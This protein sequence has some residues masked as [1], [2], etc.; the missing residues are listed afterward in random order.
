MP[1]EHQITTQLFPQLG[2]QAQALRL[3]PRHHRSEEQAGINTR[4]WNVS[5]VRGNS[6]LTLTPLLRVDGWEL[7]VWTAEGPMSRVHYMRGG[8]LRN[9]RLCPVPYRWQKLGVTGREPTDFSE[10]V[11]KNIRPF[12]DTNSAKTPTTPQ[13][14]AIHIFCERANCEHS[15]VRCRCRGVFHGGDAGAVPAALE[16]VDQVAE[17]NVL[18]VRGRGAQ[19]LPW[20]SII[21]TEEERRKDE[22]PE[23]TRKPP[24]GPEQLWLHLNPTG[25]VLLISEIG[26]PMG[27][28]AVAY[29]RSTILEDCIKDV[30]EAFSTPPRDQ[31]CRWLRQPSYRKGAR[32]C[33]R[34]THEPRTMPCSRLA[35][36]TAP[37]AKTTTA[38]CSTMS[39]PAES[40]G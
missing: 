7:E 26:T 11:D 30:G 1:A 34:P 36:Q 29:A 17:T 21:E 9:Q 22:V 6:Q 10:R 40:H 20:K 13:P 3:Q 8:G 25:G 18:D 27:F 32:R 4:H 2:Q 14:P 35:P 37:T 12:D 31:E 39:T 28:E 19:V 5:W 33:N 23:K 15:N 16:I 24:P 38:S